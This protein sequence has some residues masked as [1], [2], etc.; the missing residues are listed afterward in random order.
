LSNK[1]NQE[2]HDEAMKRYRSSGDGVNDD[3]EGVVRRRTYQYRP[4]SRW[5]RHLLLGPSSDA[6][7]PWQLGCRLYHTALS[8]SQV[9][10]VLC[11]VGLGLTDFDAKEAGLAWAL[12]RWS[13]TY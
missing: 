6:K 9:L 7:C 2:R 10:V 11:D 5:S 8:V 1:G 12:V 3:D 13:W 4:T